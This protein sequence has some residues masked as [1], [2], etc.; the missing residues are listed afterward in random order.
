MEKNQ[1]EIE[2]IEKAIEDPLENM[3]IRDTE[4]P[5]D[6]TY[7]GFRRHSLKRGST[8]GNRENSG[9]SKRRRLQNERIDAKRE[10]Y[11]SSY[12]E[13]E[14]VCPGAEWK[15][16]FRYLAALNAGPTTTRRKSA[17]VLIGEAYV[18]S[19][20][21]MTTSPVH[22]VRKLG[23][24][25]DVNKIIKLVR[26]RPGNYRQCKEQGTNNLKNY[27]CQDIV[28]TLNAM[29]I[30]L[31]ISKTETLLLV[32]PRKIKE[33]SIDI[34]GT[35]IKPSG[36]VKYL[37]IH[38]DR[39]LRMTN[40]IKH[41]NNAKNWRAK[42]AEKKNSFKLCNLSNSIW[43]PNM[44]KRFK[45]YVNL[46]TGINRKLSIMIT[47]A[48]RTAPTVAIEAV[49]GIIP[50]DLLVGETIRICERGSGYKKEARRITIDAWQERWGSY[51]GWAKVK[52]NIVVWSSGKFGETDYFIT[53]AITGY[54]IFGTYLKTIKKQPNDDCWYCSQRD[55]PEHTIFDCERF[56]SIRHQTEIACGRQSQRKIYRG[57]NTGD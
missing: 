35:I 16:G 7:E 39:N 45:H 37:G 52:R 6:N 21:E 53:Q 9:T 1:T 19:A 32:A 20:A 26:R 57:N 11:T 33:V 2:K 34:E 42:N 40:H 27:S 31:A 4:I 17:I 25:P 50:I 54:G 41:T 36:S 51:D 13:P 55:T 28:E 29:G 8:T 30:R 15:K 47:S 48:Y 43:S 46:M 23:L 38:L 12:T 56:C 3:K 22:V 44:E 10:K 5:G 14:W 49:A 24:A 18:S